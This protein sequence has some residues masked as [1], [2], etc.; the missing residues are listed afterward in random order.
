M[1]QIIAAEHQDKLQGQLSFDM[2]WQVERSNMVNSNEGVNRDSPQ[3]IKRTW[4]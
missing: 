2:R 3:Q 1:A 4:I